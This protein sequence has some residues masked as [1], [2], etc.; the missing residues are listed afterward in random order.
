MRKGNK[1]IVVISIVLA[2]VV[3]GVILAYLYLATDVFK[4]NQELFVKYISQDVNEFQNNLKFQTIDIYESLK[5]Q[6][7]YE[8]K[9]D[10]NMSHSEGGE[11][12]NPLNNLTATL[13]IQKNNEESYMYVDGQVLFENEEYLE[14]E[15]IRE[16]DIYGVRFS[17]AVQQ[18]ITVQKNENIETVANDIGLDA[19]QLEMMINILNGSE[20]LISKE[21]LIALK[22]KY[23]N[24]IMQELMNGTFEKQKDAMITYDNVTTQTNAYSVSLNSEQVE[25]MLLQI[26]NNA[27]NETEVLEKLQIIIDK[28]DAIKRIDDAINSITEEIETPTIKVTVYEQKQKV[29]R[30]IIEINSHKIIIENLEQNTGTKISYSNLTTDQVQQY[31]IEMHKQNVD[32]QENIEMHINVIEGEENYNIAVTSKIQSSDENI[33]FYIEAIQEEGIITTSVILEN[34]INIGTDFEKKQTLVLG[35]NILISS[36]EQQRRKQLI[37]VLKQIVPQKTEERTKLLEQKLGINNENEENSLIN[38]NIEGNENGISQVEVNK[39]NSKFEF[40]TGDEVSAENVKMLLDIV[41]NNFGSYEDINAQVTNVENEEETKCNVKLNIKKDV[42]NQEKINQIL[43]KIE[44]NK[45]YK[46]S[47]FYK[48]SNGIIDYITITEI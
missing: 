43:E 41:K 4:S 32:N 28:D 37:D 8:S 30:T 40:Y 5:N 29:I 15:I 25:N 42:V 13:D 10:I 22:D 3:A 19:I 48:Q 16:Q 1:L 39:F 47:I 2:L 45:K 31:E 26:L 17:D 44:N 36:L 33:E 11:I 18:F 38:E 27:K 9:T 46:I 23:L 34:Q 21:Q 20:Q 35:N 7:I 12:S 6:N 24:I 14:A